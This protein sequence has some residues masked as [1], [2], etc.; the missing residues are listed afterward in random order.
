MKWLL[1]VTFAVVISMAGAASS[2]AASGDSPGKCD[3]TKPDL[4]LPGEELSCILEI[5][6]EL[7]A[8]VNALNLSQENA[9]SAVPGG[10]VSGSS[11]EKC[12]LAELDMGPP[13][14]Q[15][16]CIL[17]IVK[18][19][20]ASVEVLKAPQVNTFS[21]SSSGAASG[22][23]PGKCDLAELDLK[24]PGEKF[25]CILEIVKELQ[26]SVE[27]LSPSQGITF[28]VGPDETLTYPSNL[29]A[30]PD[31]HTTFI[32]PAPGSN[33]YLV[34]AATVGS[35]TGA[36]VVLETT[37]LQT[38]TLAADYTQ[39]VM[40]PP[41]SFNTCKSSYDPE[42]DLNYAAPGSV[43]QDPTLPPGNLIMIFEAENHCPGGVWQQPFD[44]TVGVTRSSDN[45]KTWPPPADSELGGPDRYPVLKISTPEPT[46]AEQPPIP[47]G[48]ALPSAFV[49]GNN[50]YVTYTYVGPGSDGFARVA[51]AT[52]GGGGQISFSK[53]Y[54]GAFSEPGIGGQDSGVLPSHGCTG[55]QNMAQ[56]SYNDALRLYL[57]TFVCVSLQPDQQGVLQPYQAAW[58]FSTATSL[59]SQNWTAPQIIENSQFPVTQG[60]GI[61]G[62][63]RAFDGWYP[64]FMSPG[65]AAGNT[66]SLGYVFFMNG[67]DIGA[68]TFMARTFTITA[69]PPVVN[70][71]ITPVDLSFGNTYIG[72]S[73]NQTIT[74]TNQASST[75]VLKGN[76]GTLSAPF[77]VVSGGGTF[78]LAPGESVT[79][80]VQFL[81]TTAGSAS[82]SLSITHDA[83]N[84]TSPANIS[85]SATGV[86]VPIISV[87][88]LSDNYGNV[89]VKR[90]SS[91]SFVVKNNGKTN[92]LI[93]SAITGPDASMFK[94]TSGSGSKTIKPG[95][96]LM[97]KVTFKPISTGLKSADLEITSNDPATP[98]V[99]IALTGTGQ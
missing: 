64:S 47:L 88:P 56:I 91:A 81:P 55:Y 57:M 45:G 66:S 44:V 34:F 40:A 72:Q 60:C 33:T 69:P 68:R 19:L 50:L 75:A 13:G 37:D 79:V 7:Q 2:C 30:L 39:P 10:V 32:P 87:T 85:L 76:V 70:L 53:W 96:S 5:V 26:V 62:S 77:S 52:L 58:Y 4:G 89:K 67:C 51:R 23:I 29:K 73:A 78:N 43:V 94:I 35:L 28:S 41:L 71:S 21:T 1:S 65:S 11:P 8:S 48:D 74:I 63:G 6:R 90:S 24:S 49:D 59:D 15:L 98:S 18:E 17:E 95:K 20:Q 99:G 27:A 42:F 12:D 61:D 92:L 84:Q 9:S 82:A 14:K 38:F 22:D 25:D 93:T 86:N 97:I 54:N 80:T 46:T 31:E 3:L 16:H 83:T 36:P